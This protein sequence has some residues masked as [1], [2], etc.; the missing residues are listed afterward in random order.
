MACRE[1]LRLVQPFKDLNHQALSLS[2]GVL[3]ETHHESDE[4][5]PLGVCEEAFCPVLLEVAWTLSPICSLSFAWPLTFA[6][7]DVGLSHV[8]NHCRRRHENEAS[9]CARCRTD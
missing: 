8:H 4:P 5:S 7:S 9:C 3:I 1:E 6:T 2:S